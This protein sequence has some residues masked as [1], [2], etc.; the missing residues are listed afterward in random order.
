MNQYEEEQR[1]FFSHLFKK[2][3]FSPKT[4]HWIS[5]DTQDIR[6]LELLKIFTMCDISMQTKILDFGCGLG[7]LY[8]FLK[9]NNCI[10][11]WRIDYTGVELNQK[12]I[13]EAKKQF[14]E[15]IFKIKDDS[16]YSDNFDF[17]FCS[18]IFNL[19]FSDDF[20]IGSYY[21][22]ELQKLFNIA[23]LGI[24]VNFQSV[25]GIKL[26]QKSKLKNELARFFFHDMNK[27]VEDLKEI[28]QKIE[29][30]SSYLPNDFTV[31][32]LR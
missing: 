3:G 1:K 22:T 27:V 19:K 5:K 20:D 30:S 8:K 21:K 32:L 12:L 11:E 25:N 9:D 29:T 18:G 31:Y 17:I 23:N 13:D 15:A 7:H 14:P 2:H 10:S 28:T 26:I 4:L 24:A 6:Y 16:I